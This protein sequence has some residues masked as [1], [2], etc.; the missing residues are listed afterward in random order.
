M[1]LAENDQHLGKADTSCQL[2]NPVNATRHIRIPLKYILSK[3]GDELVVIQIGAIGTGVI[4]AVAKLVGMSDAV[5]RTAIRGAVDRV[6]GEDSTSRLCPSQWK[7]SVSN[8]LLD[9][10][11]RGICCV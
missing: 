8:G 4:P 3:L 1:R 2:F 9:K 5:T 6:V 10:L 7:H 11:R